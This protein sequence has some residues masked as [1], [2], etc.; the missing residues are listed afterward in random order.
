MLERDKKGLEDR[1]N[2]QLKAVEEL[3]FYVNKL[4]NENNQNKKVEKAMRESESK[5][6]MLMKELD[7]LNQIIKNNMGDLSE[8]K[9]R[10]NKL[11][12]S[13]NQYKQKA[14]VSKDYENKIKLL[15]E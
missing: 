2:N 8:S 4:E 11:E 5:N 10:Y 1:Y 7:R 9:A 12:E 14:E 6:D 3:K 13:M 15:G